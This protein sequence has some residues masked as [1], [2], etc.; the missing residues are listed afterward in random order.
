MRFTTLSSLAVSRNSYYTCYI[1]PR[2]FPLV[3]KYYN[4]WWNAMKSLK[5]QLFA[6]A[7]EVKYYKLAI[8]RDVLSLCYTFI[9]HFLSI[10]YP[11]VIQ[12]VHIILFECALQRQNNDVQ[13]PMQ[14]SQA[15]G[16]LY[17]GQDFLCD[18]RNPP[19]PYSLPPKFVRI[20]TEGTYL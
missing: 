12:L 10:S 14:L 8:Y 15:P 3:I 5:S 20:P 17:S 2:T 1:C 6:S 16:T 13:Q 11:S 19:V 9:I 18:R 4:M 7:Q